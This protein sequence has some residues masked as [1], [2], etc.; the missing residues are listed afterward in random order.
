MFKN[1]YV[2]FN[3][4]S[5]KDL[6]IGVVKRPDIPSPE[7]KYR[8]QEIEGRN[9]LLYE[10][11]GTYSDIEITVEFNFLEYNPNHFN[12]RLRQVKKWINNIKDTKLKFSDDLGF[13]YIVNKTKLVDS[14]REFKAL[15]KFNVV[16]TCEPFVYLEDGLIKRQLTTSL[17]NYYEKS[18]PNYEILGT[19]T[20]NL[21]VNGVTI[22]AIVSSNLII[23]TK[24][25]L[26]YKLDGTL[27][28][29]ALT[30]NYSSLLLQE[31]NNTFSYTNGFTVNIIPNWREL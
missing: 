25:G 28:N 19:G 11:L 16:F 29:T 20:I 7:R 2:I 6:K 4:S 12:D 23:N 9:G 1:F 26:S 3:N 22:T 18:Y 10:D 8:E 13:F 17:N 21:T 27:S 14:T 24:L 15:G 31:G 30:G 5:S